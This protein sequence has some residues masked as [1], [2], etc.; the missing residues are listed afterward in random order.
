MILILTFFLVIDEK[1]VDEFFV[2]LFPSKHGAYIV[3]KTE[4]VKTKVGLWLRGQVILM[5]IMF[6][7]SWIVYS[8]LGLDYALTLAMLAG[9]GELIPVV[10]IFI[11]AIPTLLVA[12]N[13]SF[14]LLIATIIA[15]IIIQQLEGNVLVPLVMKKAV[16]LS[17][18]IVI[19]AMLVGYQLLG[20]LGMVIAV[21][22]ATTLS[23]FVLDYATKKK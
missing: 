17:P 4:A 19:L 11:V 13:H 21:P 20:I 10:G 22:V 8:A 23:I 16:G 3:E 15:V 7:I 2:S 5:I 12:L 1:S 18:I 6:F 14:G 9:L